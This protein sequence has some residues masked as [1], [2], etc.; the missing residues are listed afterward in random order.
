MGDVYLKAWKRGI[1]GV[2]V[3]REGSRDAILS[4]G[5]N[6]DCACKDAEHKRPEFYDA[7]MNITVINGTPY[8]V[9]VSKCGGSIV[10]V[11]SGIA[12][13]TEPERETELYIPK[14]TGPGRIKRIKSGQYEY[15]ETNTPN[16]YKIMGKHSNPECELITRLISKQLRWGTS[17]EEIV[18]QMEKTKAGSKD[19]TKAIWK[20]LKNYIKD[21]VKANSKCDVCGAEMVRSSGC[22]V[23]PSC[24]FSKCG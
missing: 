24:G 23:C 11:F 22:I 10:E 3:Y 7:E 4:T 13:H 18:E 9:A 19:F 15:Y 12:L 14:K 20:V 6:S 2:T 8:F 5:S 17:L 21:G 16:V 1:I